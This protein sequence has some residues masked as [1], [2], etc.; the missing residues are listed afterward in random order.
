MAIFISNNN[1]YNLT[2]CGMKIFKSILVF[3]FLFSGIISQSQPLM[4]SFAPSPYSTS[5]LF[6]DTTINRN[7]GLS[8]NGVFSPTARFHIKSNSFSNLPLLKLEVAGTY[9]GQSSIIQH[10]VSINDQYY[11]IYET[12][13]NLKNYFQDPVRIGSISIEEDSTLRPIFSADNN[14]NL[15]KFVMNPNSGPRKVPLSIN[16]EGIR[17]TSNLVTNNIKILNSPGLNKVL[18]SDAAGNGTWTNVSSVNVDDHDWVKGNGILYSVPEFLRVGVHSPNPIAQFQINNGASKLAFGSINDSYFNYGNAYIGFNAARVN[19]GVPCW[20][21]EQDSH[22]QNGGGVIWSGLEGSINFT[23]I[24]SSGGS[25]GSNGNKEAVR[26]SDADI[27]SQTRMTITPTGSVGIGTTQPTQKLQIDHSDET[28]GIVINQISDDLN[29]NTSE[30]RFEK[31]GIEKFALGYW[32]NA[33]RP[34]FFIWNHNPDYYRTALF[35]NS[36]NNNT[37]IDTEWPNAKLDVNGDLHVADRI[38]IGCDAPEDKLYK[39]FVEG[40]IAARD[41]KVTTHNP[42]PD[43]IFSDTYKLLSLDD[44]AKF[45]ASN[46]HLPGMPSSKE[47]ESNGGFELGAMQVKLIEKIEEQTQYILDMQKQIDELKQQITSLIKK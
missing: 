5:R 38:G 6:E 25:Q 40:G 20:A 19:E 32:K 21:L 12:S 41:V 36:A 3:V 47:V 28:G 11:G 42:F 4:K 37:G 23:T 39:L 14:V 18:V 34:S 16:S 15:I 29:K 30:I 44:L 27:L 46:K 22:G 35:I 7:I 43:Y 45:I 13:G 33:S 17:V 26:L 8:P 10:M 24:R 1:S 2:L 9:Q 31:N